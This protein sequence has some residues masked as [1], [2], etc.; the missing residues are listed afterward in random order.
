MWTGEVVF[1]DTWAAYSGAAADQH[2]HVHAA[3]QIVVS[4]SSVSIEEPGQPT[5]S[6]SALFVRPMVRH[7]LVSSEQPLVL[8]YLDPDG[9][10]ART[11][12]KDLPEDS[13]GRLPRHLQH[14]LGHGVADVARFL[15]AETPVNSPSVVLEKRL[16]EA[17]R[18]IADDPSIGAVGRAAH[19]AGL[20]PSRLRSLA[21]EHLGI[22][23]SQWMTW[24]K[25]ARSCRSMAV[26]ETLA[27]AAQS[28]GFADQAHF[29]RTMKRM[30]GVTPAAIAHPL[31]ALDTDRTRI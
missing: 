11:I 10:A 15:D 12:L 30:M 28:G 8:I 9:I 5:V 1:G 3:L 27:Q 22:A 25:L 21:Q 18:T 4:R 23:L 29:T 26:G 17:L 13:M 14:R 31:A 2:P 6:G 16:G 19:A 20:S 24:R 7:R